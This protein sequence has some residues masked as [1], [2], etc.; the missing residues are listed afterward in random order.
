[1]V[2]SQQRRALQHAMDSAAAYGHLEVVLWFHGT[3]NEGCMVDAVEKT[4][5]HGHLDV[6]AWLLMLG[7]FQVECVDRGKTVGV[8]DDLVPQESLIDREAK[9]E[10]NDVDECPPQVESDNENASKPSVPT[11]KSKRRSP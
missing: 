9:T 11:Q 7:G 2:A 3:R 10:N 6:I 8:G 4:A 1:M 5:L